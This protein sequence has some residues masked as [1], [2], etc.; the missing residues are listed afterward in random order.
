MVVRGEIEPAFA[1]EF[2]QGMH[3]ISLKI[4]KRR[5]LLEADAALVRSRLKPLRAPCLIL[6][7]ICLGRDHLHYHHQQQCHHPL[8]Q[9]YFSQ[10]RTI[11]F[12]ISTCIL[13]VLRSADGMHMRIGPQVYQLRNEGLTREYAG[14]LLGLIT[15]SQP[16]SW[17]NPMNP[18]YVHYGLI[19][20]E[21]AWCIVP[22]RTQQRVRCGCLWFMSRFA[23]YLPHWSDNPASFMND[24]L[25]SEE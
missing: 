21:I 1:F 3:V 24:A 15:L 25:W 9:C 23:S 13:Q 16:S 7:Y 19:S 2:I 6:F 8:Y 22:T 11:N 4:Q 5:W 17:S 10:Q 14:Q 18:S 12:Q 20:L